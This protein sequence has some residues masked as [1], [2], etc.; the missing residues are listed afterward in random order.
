MPGVSA[1]LTG[2]DLQA[3]DIGSLPVVWEITS[4]DGSPAVEPAFPALA[5]DRV[6]YV[7]NPVAVVVAE[8]RV[9][10]R[11][12]AEMVDVHYDELE[13]VSSAA[14]ALKRALR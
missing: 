8:T 7:G 5:T 11:D 4:K 6:R 10:A 3:D 12:A 1:I 2:A 9:Q 13:S 14:A